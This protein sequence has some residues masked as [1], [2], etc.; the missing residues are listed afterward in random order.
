[1]SEFVCRSCGARN[2]TQSKY[3]NK[4]GASLRSGTSQICPSCEKANP[5]ELLYCDHCGTLLAEDALLDPSDEETD[6]KDTPDSRSKPFSLPTRPPGQTG[7]LDVSGDIPGWL[8]TGDVDQDAHEHDEDTPDWLKAAEPSDE[9]EDSEAPTLEDLSGSHAPSDD[10][11]TWLLEDE[12]GDAIFNSEKDTNELFGEGS[13]GEKSDA[14][15]EAPEA[16]EAL[17]DWLEGLSSPGT[18]PLPFVADEEDESPGGA[19][20]GEHPREERQTDDV[21]GELQSWLS[22]IEEDESADAESEPPAAASAQEEPASEEADPH[23]DWP[24]EFENGVDEEAQMQM[25]LVAPDDGADDFARWLTG[26]EVQQSA[27]EEAEAPEEAPPLQSL[28][29]EGFQQWLADTRLEDSASLSDEAEEWQAEATPV[30]EDMPGDLTPE[31]VE[32]QEAD[33]DTP[34]WLEVPEDEYLAEGEEPASAAPDSEA[35]P[36]WLAELEEESSDEIEQPFPDDEDDAGWLPSIEPASG[37]EERQADEA[38]REEMTE[39]DF[40]AWLA[41]LDEGGLDAADPDEEA[42]AAGED[43]AAGEVSLTADEPGEEVESFDSEEEKVSQELDEEEASAELPSW[44]GELANNEEAIAGD[45]DEFAGDLPEWLQ[46]MPSTGESGPLPYLEAD[47]A[48]D[49]LADVAP[50]PDAKEAMEAAGDTTEA[51]E[52]VP[53]WL[54]GISDEFDLEAASPLEGDAP[55]VQDEIRQPESV[56]TQKDDELGELEFADASLDPDASDDLVPT[57]DLPDWFSDVMADIETEGELDSQ[58][59][60]PAELSN[61]PSQLAADELPE[62][63]DSPFADGPDA[64]PTPLEEIPE[65]L[66]PPPGA[67]LVISDADEELLSL[68]AAESSDEW[69]DL[70]DA[71]PPPEQDRQS[72]SQADIPEWLQALKPQAL[73]EDSEETPAPPEPEESEGPLA[74]LRG[75]IGVAPA[76]AHSRAAE[77]IDP[78]LSAQEHKQQVALLRQLARSEGQSVSRRTLPTHITTQSTT[79]RLLLALLLLVALFIGLFFPETIVELTPWA[80]VGAPVEATGMINAA[81]GEPVIVA[82]EYTPALAGAL[83]EDA[84]SV[85]DMLANNGSAA[86]LVSQTAAGATLARQA[87]S[88]TPDLQ[89]VD[90][91]YIP[92]GAAGLRSMAQCLAGGQLC[93]SLFGRPLSQDDGAALG[94]AALIILLSGERSQLIDWVEQVQTTS[95]ISMLAFVTEAIAPVA[96]P[97]DSSHQ[98]TVVASSGTSTLAPAGQAMSPQTVAV[99]LGRWLAIGTILIGAIYYVVAGQR[100]TRTNG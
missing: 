87:A 97:Y 35:A 61:V 41:T 26:E 63:L 54:A 62:W 76:M 80:P 1:M 64:E 100:R 32:S 43:E 98:L 85:L 27:T 19:E 93:D 74:G 57:E 11:P 75:V 46:S 66:K 34:D 77:R 22:A 65:W 36:D 4:C 92:G 21:A 49:E 95:N 3:C 58:A 23:S 30:E 90:V 99:M 33:V 88:D 7:D 71:L 39:E 6:E 37:E 55:I 82:F 17:P 91:G 20:P 70:L 56:E 94:D 42:T 13:A 72:L 24:Q 38:S 16:D 86:I 40:L 68:G 47:E 59:D 28:D 50:E 12:A 52:E 89:S 73:R 67:D 78:D 81:A 18:G 79:I 14:T 84:R 9:Q 53:E 96:A 5:I 69:A 51:G 10:L 44:L 29:E 31:R 15:E 83:E 25:D 48:Q 2:P 45:D 60:V 8:K